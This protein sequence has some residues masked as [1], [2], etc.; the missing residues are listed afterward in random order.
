MAIS[1]TRQKQELLLELLEEVQSTAVVCDCDKNNP[2][3]DVK[4]FRDIIN[5]KMG[6]L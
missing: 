4:D 2:R 3:L 6:E 1:T 5:R